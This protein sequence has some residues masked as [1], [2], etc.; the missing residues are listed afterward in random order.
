MTKQELF[1]ERRKRIDAAVALKE[2]DRVPLAPKIGFFY[3]SAYGIPSYATLM[4]VRNTIPGL[5][6]YMEEYQPDLVWPPAVYPAKAAN[7]LGSNFI[8]FPGYADG[9]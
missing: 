3:G 4:D 7:A 2:H 6:A 9:I 1:T 8:K 5:K